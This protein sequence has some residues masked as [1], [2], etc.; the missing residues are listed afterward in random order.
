MT[1]RLL[2]SSSNDLGRF[3]DA[4]SRRR[5]D[6]GG[7]VDRDVVGIIDAVRRRGDRA[8]VEFTRKFDGV[9]VSPAN[10]RVSA[11]ELAAAFD[12]MPHL[13]RRA[14]ELAA[15]RITEFHRHTLENLSAIAIGTACASA[16][17]CGHSIASVSTCPAGWA[18]IHHPC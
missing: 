4:L 2:D 6:N 17:W 13:D 12:A 11:V 14:L 8:L 3:L 16:K 5:G 18:R 15:R 10:L 1:L 9:S 7:A